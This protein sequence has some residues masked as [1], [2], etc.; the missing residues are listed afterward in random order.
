MNNKKKTLWALSIEEK[1]I[2]EN[3]IKYTQII[4]HLNSLYG[5]EI[6]DCYNH[7]EYL[8]NVLKEKY[9]KKNLEM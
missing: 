9:I 4:K 7:H 2:R 1:L 6:I 3:K 5:C 8:E